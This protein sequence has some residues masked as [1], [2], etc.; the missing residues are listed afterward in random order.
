MGLIPAALLDIVGLVAF[1]TIGR[2]S[3]D[4]GGGVGAVLET[5]A[6]FLVAL[7]LGWALVL[8]LG[9]TGASRGDPRHLDGGALIWLVTVVAGLLLRRTLWERGT[10]LAF[11][12]VAT[13]FIGFVLL[14]WRA[15]YGWV[16]SR[17]SPA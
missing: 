14:G 16:R 12:V 8:A 6:P 13:L 10:A 2:R 3:H 11:V 9:R 7:A 15:A 4:E 5:A 17:R 1:A